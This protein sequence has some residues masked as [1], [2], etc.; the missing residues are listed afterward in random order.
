VT[1]NE[2][3][4]ETET[5]TDK[6]GSVSIETETEKGGK[7]EV[8]ISLKRPHQGTLKGEVSLYR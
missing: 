3:E 7:D 5:K 2:T 4:A 8:T 1:G 6:N